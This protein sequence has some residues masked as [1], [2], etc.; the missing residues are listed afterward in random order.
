MLCIYFAVVETYVREWNIISHHSEFCDRITILIYKQHS[1]LTSFDS[2][3]IILLFMIIVLLIIIITITIIIVNIHISIISFKIPSHIINYSKA[4]HK[5]MTIDNL[6]TNNQPLSILSM[7][8]YN[9]YILRIIN[10]IGNKTMDKQITD[11]IQNFQRYVIYCNM[12]SNCYD[13][14]YFI[15]IWIYKNHSLSISFEYN[16]IIL[17]FISIVLL[18]II[19]IITI[20]IVNTCVGT[21]SINFPSI[22]STVTYLQHNTSIA[23]KIDHLNNEIETLSIISIV[24]YIN[25]IITIIN[26]IKTNGINKQL[27]NKIKTFQTWHQ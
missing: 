1:T 4:Q 25:Y 21:I 3:K 18:V 17:I 13:F 24:I 7:L 10:L 22:R 9:N 19:T 5:G 23:I 8:I 20:I 2:C 27:T 14:G 15:N 26:S 16:V 6:N 11:K 12:I